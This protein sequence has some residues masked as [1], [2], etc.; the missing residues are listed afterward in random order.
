MGDT[1]DVTVGEPGPERE[2]GQSSGPRGSNGDDPG[3]RRAESEER[4]PP[5]GRT[6]HA[7]SPAQVH[8]GGGRVV[9][10]EGWQESLEEGLILIRAG[11]AL[12][13]GIADLPEVAVPPEGSPRPLVR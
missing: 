13:L 10:R 9:E 5:G 2:S 3:P 12:L 11:V 7:T 1:P 4:T 8:E 6:G